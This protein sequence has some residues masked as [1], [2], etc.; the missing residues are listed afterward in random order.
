L[1]EDRV[2]SSALRDLKRIPQ[3]D[4]GAIVSG[5]TAY[6]DAGRGDV[7]ALK[8][9]SDFRL[10]IG[11]WRVIFDITAGLVLIRHVLRRSE[12]TYR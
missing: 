5:V 8:D 7:R 4:R 3:G 9:Q 6:A 2:H 12:R 10:R 11:A 1:R